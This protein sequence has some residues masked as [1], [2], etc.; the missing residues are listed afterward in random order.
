MKVFMKTLLIVFF[1]VSLTGCATQGNL[2]SKMEI[3]NDSEL[4]QEEQIPAKKEV[5]NP[6]LNSDKVLTGLNSNIK[7][8]VSNPELNLNEALSN[9]TSQIVNSMTEGAKKKVAVIEFSDL[10]SNVSKFGKYLA[11]ELITRLFMT[12]KFE[13]IERRLLNKVLSEQKLSLSDL[14]DPD[15]IV[16]LGKILGVDAIVSGTITDLVTSLKVNARI[17]STETGSVFAV[18]ATEIIKDETVRNLM[19]QVSVIQTPKVKE[20]KQVEEKPIE[21][22]VIES[23]KIFFKEDFSE[24][25]EGFVPDGWIG[26]EHLMVRTESR[27]GRKYLTPFEKGSKK[28]SIQKMNFPKNFSI[29][30]AGKFP[31]QH[32]TEKNIIISIGNL[33][34]IV[35]YYSVNLGDTKGKGV[36]STITDITIVKQGPLFKLYIDGG[37]KLLARYPNFTQPTSLIIDFSHSSIDFELYE[38]SGTELEE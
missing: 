14:I 1:I 37:Q 24:V 25:D 29:N 21:K 8:G 31:R 17:I 12:R 32:N 6:E 33:N 38:I 15:S 9:L 26:C 35:G 20:L 4:R 27:S 3:R 7:K 13:V 5:A 34:T 36:A 19:S 2:E 30:I 16:D 28:I 10:E 11:E 18:A 22:K 23:D